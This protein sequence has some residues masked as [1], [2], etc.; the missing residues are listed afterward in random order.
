[1]CTNLLKTG[2]EIAESVWSLGVKSAG[3]PNPCFAVKAGL[4]SV[5]DYNCHCCPQPALVTI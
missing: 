3:L 2:V 1:M 5:S 4:N